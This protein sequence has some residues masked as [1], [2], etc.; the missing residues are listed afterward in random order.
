MKKTLLVLLTSGT[1]LFTS[2]QSLDMGLK[3]GLAST[4]L[5]NSNVYNGSIQKYVTTFTPEYGLHF[6]FNFIGG[7]GIELEAIFENFEQ[8]HNGTF[9]DNGFMNLDNHEYTYQ[10]NESYTSTTEFNEIKIPLLFHYQSKSGFAL[11]VGPQYNMIS[12]ASFSSSYSGQPPVLL[13]G[14]SSLSYSV[15]GDFSSSC[16]V[17]VLGFG[18]NIKLIPS[19]KLYLLTDL[20][21]E[22]GFTDIK[23]I[24]AFGQNM[25]AAS[26][27]NA[28]AAG[29][30]S[31]SGNAATNPAEVSFTVGL[32]YR[33]G[34]LSGAKSLL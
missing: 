28:K 17:G 2:A 26:A 13:G 1:A 11:E 9:K 7:T 31:Y 8:K 4:W 18:W 34:F 5:L 15:Q 3:G 14:V 27:S 29:Y 24:D 6:Q 16:I 25:A 30:Y 22:Y 33:L 10:D 21:M 19:G 32:F 12:N 20:R 23:G